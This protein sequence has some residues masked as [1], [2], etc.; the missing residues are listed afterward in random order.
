MARPV[1]TVVVSE[2]G[3]EG[4]HCLVLTTWGIRQGKY[5]SLGRVQIDGYSGLP[6][7]TLADLARLV[8][9]ALYGLDYDL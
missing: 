2:F 9:T 7:E 3:T 5:G 4:D 8:L 6:C 1:L